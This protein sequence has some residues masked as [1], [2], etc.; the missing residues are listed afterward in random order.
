MYT[1]GKM[2]KILNAFDL[3]TKLPDTYALKWTF[4]SGHDTDISAMY[5]GMNLSS[6]NCIE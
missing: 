2:E 5:L 4:L 1:S 6:Y 3:R